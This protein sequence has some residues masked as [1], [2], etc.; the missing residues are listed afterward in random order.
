MQTRS[1]RTFL[2]IVRVGS[3]AR[4]AEHLNMTLS[5]VSMQMKSLEAELGT[6]LFDRS[7]RPPRLTPVAREVSRHVE[8]LLQTEDALIETCRPGD[9]LTG[10]FRIGFVATASVRLLPDFLIASRQQAPEARFEIET[11]LSETLEERVLT[12]QIDAA[13]LTAAGGPGSGLL[14]HRLRQEDLAYAAPE[15]YAEMA[16]VQL[17]QALPFFH[18]LPHSG[19]GKLIARCVKP[20]KLKGLESVYLDSVEAIMECVNRGIG[21]TMLPVPDIERYANGAACLTQGKT[22]DMKRDLVLASLA[23]GGIDVR[24]GRIAALFDGRA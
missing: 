18:F 20:I 16:P 22:P 5:A 17:A 23:K 2:E 11:G 10:V 12:G 14:Y 1:L 4:A 21:F 6:Q 9:R 8:T 24:A 15:R 3:F 13:V 7:A 19:I